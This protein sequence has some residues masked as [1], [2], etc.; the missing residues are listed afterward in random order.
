MLDEL[1]KTMWK[2]KINNSKQNFLNYR[3]IVNYG[4]V[5]LENKN[6]FNN[7]DIIRTLCIYTEFCSYHDICDH[8]RKKEYKCKPLND[9]YENVDLLQLKLEEI[10]LQNV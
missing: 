8:R 9:F 7:D 5:S 4:T 1:I 10:I 2:L 3:L 6:D